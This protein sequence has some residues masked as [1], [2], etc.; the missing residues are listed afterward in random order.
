[1]SLHTKL[2]LSFF[3]PSAV[4]ATVNAWA[5]RAFPEQWGGPNIGGGFIQLLAYAGMLVGVIFFVLAVMKKR[6]D[7]PTV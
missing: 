1:M 5:F 6:R 4:V 2:A 3:V 7:K